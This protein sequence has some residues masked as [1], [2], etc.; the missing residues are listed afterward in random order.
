M[1]TS[2][3]SPVHYGFFPRRLSAVPTSDEDC[4][5]ED[6]CFDQKAKISAPEPAPPRLPGRARLLAI[7]KMRAADRTLPMSSAET[8]PTLMQ[9]VPPDPIPNRP[10]GWRVAVVG[11][12]APIANQICGE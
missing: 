8:L 7:P 4:L 10:T 2:S 3:Q 5:R 6:Q 9:D 11:C 1:H 12:P